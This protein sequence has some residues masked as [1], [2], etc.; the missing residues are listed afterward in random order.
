MKTTLFPWLALAG[1]AL[2][3]PSLAADKISVLIIDGQNNHKWEITTPVLKD[4]LESSG[5]FLV[6]VSTTPAKKAPAASWSEWHPKFSDYAVIVSN[7]NGEPWPEPVRKDFDQYVKNGGGFVSVHAANNSFPEWKEYNQMIGVGGW[8]GRNEASGPWLYVKDGK[9]FRDSS[10]GN[11]GAHGPQHE[12]V[13]EVQNADH[14]ITRGLPQRWLHAQ[15]ELYSKL[16]GPA[17]NIKILASA[18]SDL[19][20]EQEPNLM[21]LHYGKGRVFHTTLG[22]ADYSMLCRDFYET[23]QRGTEWAASGD[24]TQTADLPSDFPTEH[25]VSPVSLEGYPKQPRQAPAAKK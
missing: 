3:L 20:G 14:P 23:L 10:A 2:S 4:A 5:A 1:M 16:R 17:E 21:V 25:Q 11:G 13:V 6:Q 22:H 9:L 19:T 8:G 12:F 24:V 15:D 18:K 7:Y